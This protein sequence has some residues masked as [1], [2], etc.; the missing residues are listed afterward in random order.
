[1]RRK[2]MFLFLTFALTITLFPT[3]AFQQ[4]RGGG[5]NTPQTRETPAGQASGK[6]LASYRR[7]DNGVRPEWVDTALNRSL[8]HLRREAAK[9]DLANADA[10]LSLLQARRDDLG[11]THVRLEQVY[12]GVPVFG[13]QLIMHLDRNDPDERARAFANGRVYD[14][15]RLISTRPRLAAPAALQIAKRAIGRESGF[16]SENV[17]LVIL[18]EAVRLDNDAPGATLTYKVDL[19]IDNEYEAARPVYFIDARNGNVVWNYD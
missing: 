14:D 6:I 10:E 3:R 1:M 4:G 17:E 11:Q 19:L 8:A 12:K 15:A 5:V 13:G 9:H 2:I 16:A 7:G 18:P